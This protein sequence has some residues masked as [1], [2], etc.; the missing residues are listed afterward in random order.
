VTG[1]VDTL[2]VETVERLLD[3]TATFEVVERA[4][5]DGWC[6]TVWDALAEAGFPWISVP[7]AA[8]GSD[9]T[10]ADAM[11]VV[12]SVGRHAAP[13]P[14]AET[15]VLAGWLLAAGGFGVRSEPA[16]VVADPAALR[17]RGR[18]I[19]GDSVVAWGQRSSVIAALV[20]AEDGW[21]IVAARPEQLRITPGRNMAGEP[22]DT[23]RWDVPLQDI[24]HAPAPDGVNGDALRA[25]GALTRVVLMAGAMEAIAQRAVDYAHARHQ[26]GRPIATLSGRP[27][28]SRARRPVSNPSVHG[29]RC[30]RPGDDQRNGPF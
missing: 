27:A 9:G 17:V 3:S 5:A 30:R 13:V 23:V 1:L 29:R 14:I 18:R 26:F 20:R 24:E 2:L 10:L 12:R 22:R 25:R 11:A 6:A 28:A 16:S 21:T 4:E 7:A 8:G 19:E 15:G